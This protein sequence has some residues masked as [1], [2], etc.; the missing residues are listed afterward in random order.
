MTW[1]RHPDAASASAAAASAQIRRR[2]GKG[3]PGRAFSRM[4]KSGTDLLSRTQLHT[5]IGAAPFHGPV[6]DGKA[7]F[8]NAMSTR[9]NLSPCCEA[10]GP[11]RKKQAGVVIA[12][13]RVRSP[14]TDVQGYRVKPH[15][16]L[17][18]VSLTHYCAS[19]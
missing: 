5:I 15:G 3:P 11:I 13:L 19:T 16:Q 7:W 9:H 1:E 8:Q 10:T 6:R 4:G 17:V 14:R 12:A 2:N 18:P